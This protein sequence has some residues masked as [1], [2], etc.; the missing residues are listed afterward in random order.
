MSKHV[1]DKDGRLCTLDTET[2][3]LV[4]VNVISVP[5]RNYN[6]FKGGWLA[7][8]QVALKKIVT[9]EKMNQTDYKVF[10]SICAHLDYENYLMVQQKEIALEIGMQ[11]THFNRSLKKLVQ[12]NILE[13]GD[14]VG[15]SNTYR[16]A[17]DVGWKGTAKNH[18]KEFVEKAEKATE[19]VKNQ[20]NLRVIK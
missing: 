11:P 5:I 15:R 8:S 16:L 17:P 6:A 18:K 4:P 20:S 9:N 1:R 3:E 14:K 12:L 2:G 7:M 13:L 10:L 19:A